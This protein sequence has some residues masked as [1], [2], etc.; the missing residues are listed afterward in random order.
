VCDWNIILH[1]SIDTSLDLTECLLIILELVA[2]NSW[3]F[4]L[5]CHNSAAQCAYQAYPIFM[6]LFSI[7]VKPGILSCPQMW[8]LHLWSASLYSATALWNCSSSVT[9]QTSDQRK[10]T[11]CKRNQSCD[12]WGSN[13]GS[14]WSWNSSGMWCY[15]VGWVVPGVLKAYYWPLDPEG[16]STAVLKLQETTCPTTQCHIPEDWIFSTCVI[17]P[18]IFQ[19]IM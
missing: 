5:A 16:E 18:E 10:K 11:G 9:V 12:V 7:V 19:D 8:S 3:S 17:E 1:K 4:T 14:C 2:I 6:I 15:A 13:N